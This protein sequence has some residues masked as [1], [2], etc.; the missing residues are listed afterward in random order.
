MGDQRSGGGIYTAERVGQVDLSLR[1]RAVEHVE[2][3]LP[4]QIGRGQLGGGLFGRRVG[5][6]GGCSCGGRIGEAV[7]LGDQCCG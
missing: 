2:L 3:L 5:G 4:R 7:V 6:R 1:A